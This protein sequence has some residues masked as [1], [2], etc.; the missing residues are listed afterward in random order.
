MA[1]VN[2]EL[3]EILDA[4]IQAYHEAILSA[5]GE[6]AELWDGLTTSHGRKEAWHRLGVDFVRLVTQSAKTTTVYLQ[7]WVTIR[8]KADLVDTADTE[9]QAHLDSLVAVRAKWVERLQKDKVE[10][11]GKLNAAFGSSSLEHSPAACRSDDSSLASPPLI[12]R[13]ESF[14]SPLDRLNAAQDQHARERDAAEAELARHRDSILTLPKNS[15][16]SL[17][18]LLAVSEQSL[19]KDFVCDPKHFVNSVHKFLGQG[20]VA[21]ESF[22]QASTVRTLIS[23]QAALEVKKVASTS[24]SSPLSWIQI[25]AGRGQCRREVV[26]LAADDLFA[27]LKSEHPYDDKIVD[28][29]RKIADAVQDR[30]CKVLEFH[31]QSADCREE[32]L[33]PMLAQLHQVSSELVASRDSAIQIWHKQTQGKLSSESDCVTPLIKGGAIAETECRPHTHSP[34]TW[35]GLHMIIL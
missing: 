31:E 24:S 27:K 26:R 13:A 5:A 3:Q 29:S 23:Q 2:K 6:A 18:V 28:A 30:A 4:R 10:L 1:E 25:A 34:R 22:Q 15:L 20:E 9:Y 8:L 19:S 21:F 12:H 7:E 35:H 16:N 32:E 17:D 33:R 11:V 14:T